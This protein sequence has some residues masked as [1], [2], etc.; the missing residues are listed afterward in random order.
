MAKTSG[1]DRMSV[2][3]YF[4]E[5]PAPEAAQTLA[6]ARAAVRSRKHGDGVP[7]PT[8]G[9]KEQRRGLPGKAATVAA[10]P[11]EPVG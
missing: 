10:A 3:Q 9:G 2:V 4:L 1:T 7:A 5:A 8:R 6:L 11:A